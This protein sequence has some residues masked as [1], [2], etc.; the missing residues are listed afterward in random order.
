L[1]VA[2]QWSLTLASLMKMIWS[3]PKGESFWAWHAFTPNGKVRFKNVLSFSPLVVWC[4][5]ISINSVRCHVATGQRPDL[6]EQVVLS[7]IRKGTKVQSLC[8]NVSSQMLWDF[9]YALVW[10]TSAKQSLQCYGLNHNLYDEDVVQI[11]T[12]IYVQQRQS[13][14][15][16]AM[17]QGFSDKYHKKK[18]GAKKQEQ[19]CREG[20]LT[21][22]EQYQI[23]S[24]SLGV[25]W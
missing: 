17:V 9:N 11:V 19:S 21:C 1:S 14:E 24:R 6:E 16:Q 12:K 25:L 15:Y 3:S 22:I 4:T 5:L 18:Y 23:L 10:E 20:R 7:K 2:W 13:R 8:A